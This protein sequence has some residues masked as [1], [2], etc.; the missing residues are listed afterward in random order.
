MAS[1]PGSKVHR[2]D[3]RKLG[4][5]QQVDQ[6]AANMVVTG[7]ASTATLTFNVPVVVNGT[8]PMVYGGSRTILSQTVVSATVVQQLLSNTVTMQ[9]Y[10]FTGGSPTVRTRQGGIVNSVAGTFP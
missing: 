7:S 10:S 1:Y 4:R 9:T 3:R 6:P 5:G 8:I 2:V